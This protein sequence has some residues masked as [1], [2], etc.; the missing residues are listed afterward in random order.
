MSWPRA[1]TE[2]IQ[3]EPKSSQ[4]IPGLDWIKSTWT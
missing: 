1:Q 2:P 4:V 3:L